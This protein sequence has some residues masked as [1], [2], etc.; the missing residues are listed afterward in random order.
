MRV[1]F[2]LDIDEISIVAYKIGI[3][4][5][6]KKYGRKTKEFSGKN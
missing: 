1:E 3:F 5:K 2:Y 4:S 6:R